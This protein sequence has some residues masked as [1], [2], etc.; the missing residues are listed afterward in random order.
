MHE[1]SKTPISKPDISQR[2]QAANNFSAQ[3]EAVVE[4][5]VEKPVEKNS[6]SKSNDDRVRFNFQGP[7]SLRDEIAIAMTKNKQFAHKS[8][9]MIRCIRFGLANPEMI[10]PSKKK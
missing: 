6:A 4:K 3:N 7:E 2:L 1:M 5:A 8:D 9:F 10:L